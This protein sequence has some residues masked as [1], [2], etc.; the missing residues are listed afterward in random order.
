MTHGYCPPTRGAAPHRRPSR[1]ADG[2]VRCTGGAV[3]GAGGGAGTVGGGGGEGNCEYL[4]FN[5]EN[6]FQLFEKRFDNLFF[7]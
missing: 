7:G 5:N 4:N 3:E 6:S 1:C 2:V